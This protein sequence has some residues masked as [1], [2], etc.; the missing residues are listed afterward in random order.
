M[1]IYRGYLSDG[2]FICC[3][4][5]WFKIKSNDYLLANYH[6]H[7][8][9]T[10]YWWAVRRY[11]GPWRVFDIRDLWKEL[12]VEVDRKDWVQE[13]RYANNQG[14][15][16][17]TQFVAEHLSKI[18]IRPVMRARLPEY[19]EPDESSETETDNL[20]RES[21]QIMVEGVTPKPY[22]PLNKMQ[23]RWCR[24]GLLILVLC[25]FF[26]VLKWLY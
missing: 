4:R 15:M 23:F 24:I 1:K 16:H 25:S 3:V 20:I 22:V 6:D 2:Y 12:G 11:K 19:D 7:D 10:N 17:G 26:G 18:G 8:G 9:G 13:K 21:D 14:D 5:K